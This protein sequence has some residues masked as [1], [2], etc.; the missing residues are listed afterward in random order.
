MTAL[1]RRTQAQRDAINARAA[2]Y[3][4][5]LSPTQRLVLSCIARAPLRY[6]GG[7]RWD[8]YGDKTVNSLVGRRLARIEGKQRMRA[9][10]TPAGR[11]EL[12]RHRGGR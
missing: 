9:V 2:A 7:G 12:A 6:T 5:P 8:G 4:K 11:R 3:P 1:R 10:I